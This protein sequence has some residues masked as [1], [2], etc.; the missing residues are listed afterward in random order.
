MPNVKG[1]LEH[2]I[3]IKIIMKLEQTHIQFKSTHKCQRSEMLHT[4]YPT[5]G[6]YGKCMPHLKM[7]QKKRKGCI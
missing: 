7:K 6:V 3:I 5:V 2:I 1:R 4:G